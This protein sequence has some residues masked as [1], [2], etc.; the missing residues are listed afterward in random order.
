MSQTKQCSPY[1]RQHLMSGNEDRCSIAD[2]H[3]LVQA[4]D[5]KRDSFVLDESVVYLDQDEDVFENLNAAII[6]VLAPDFPLASGVTA[7]LYNLPAH[8][9]SFVYGFA[10]HQGNGE[11]AFIPL[12]GFCGETSPS[13]LQAGS[14]QQASSKRLVGV[15]DDDNV[16]EYDARVKKRRHKRLSKT[17][18]DT[19]KHACPFNIYDPRMHCV[20]NEKG[21]TGGHYSPCM[22]LR[23]T[24]PRRLK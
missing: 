4:S 2:D 15:F 12:E 11:D 18:V 7:H 3:T 23:F 10:S 5:G 22:G 19:L 17:F 16:A 8:M 1:P 24:E 6:D 20:R 9:R 21:G 13:Q 14:E